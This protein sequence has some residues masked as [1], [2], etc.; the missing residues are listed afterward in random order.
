[1]GTLP[2]MQTIGNEEGRVFS[3]SL[4]QGL[5]SVFSSLFQQ[6]KKLPARFKQ[7]YV[8][9]T[10]SCANPEGIFFLLRFFF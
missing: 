8:V 1:M 6:L 7:S 2:G 5:N 3:P 9:L 10:V 4:I